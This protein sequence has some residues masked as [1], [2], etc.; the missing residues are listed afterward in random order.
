MKSDE[1]GGTSH[2]EA[3]GVF[4]IW[5]LS[6]DLNARRPI[7]GLGRRET[8]PGARSITQLSRDLVQASHHAFTT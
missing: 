4:S 8:A 6:K 2:Q 3:H 5:R 7:N 1:A